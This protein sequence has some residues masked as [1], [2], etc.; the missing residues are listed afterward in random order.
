MLNTQI[1]HPLPA[2]LVATLPCCDLLV[3][4]SRRAQHSPLC[5]EYAGA[6]SW[7][8][9]STGVVRSLQMV[10]LRGLGMAF[11]VLG[12]QEHAADGH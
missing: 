6:C 2:D 10:I 1:P 9:L 12:L 8:P 11:P 3:A 5:T 4:A 7:R